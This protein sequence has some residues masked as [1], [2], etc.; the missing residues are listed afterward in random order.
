MSLLPG[1][2]LGPYE[3]LAPLGAGGMGEVYRAKDTRLERTVAIKVLPQHLSSNE[4]VRQRFER[5]AK[6]ISQLSHPHICALHDI[7]REGET[8]Y[9]VM[10]YLEGETLSDRLAKGPLP[11]ERTLRYGIEIADALD[12][13]HRHGIVHRDLKPGNVM[14]TKTGVKLLD[15]GLAKAFAPAARVESLTSAPTVARDVTREGTILGTVSYMA[16]E[17]LEGKEADART[18][19]F[20]FGAVLYEMAT[21]KKAFSGTSQASVVTAIMS[22]EPAPISRVQP[23]C[24]PALDRVVQT[25]LAKDPEE[26]WQSAADLASELSW[27]AEG[28]AAAPEVRAAAGRLARLG[29][30]LAGLLLI[31]LV[32]A[33]A[34]PGLRPRRAA[35]A[36]VRFLVSPP[37]KTSFTHDVTGHNVAMSPDGWHLVFV[38]SEEGR[39]LLWVR[40]LDSV[41]PRRL[42][43]TDG[44]SSPF[45]SPDSRF[46][47]FFAEGKIKRVALSGGPPQTIG[48]SVSGGAASWGPDGTILFA[49]N[50]G[51]EGIYRISSAGGPVTQLTRF[52]KKRG[53]VWHS[54]PCF[55]PDG[56]H[57]LYSVWYGPEGKGSIRLGS[58]D[59]GDVREIVPARSRA[60]YALEGYL[61]YVRE[62]ALLAQPFDARRLRLSGEP[63]SIAERVPYFSITGGADFSVSVAGVLVFEEGE[64]QARLA[65]FDRGG[66]EVGSV[67]APRNLETPAI[68]RDGRRVAVGVTDPKTGS[69]D[70]WIHETG[71]EAP[72]RFTFTP[73]SEWAPLFSPDGGRVAFGRDPG[74]GFVNLRVKALGD[75]GEGEPVA[76]DGVFQIPHDWSAD[77]RF[78]LYTDYDSKTKDDIWILPLEG[79][80]KP[81][82]FL[83]T[84]FE[85][86]DGRFSPGGRWIAYVTDES[87]RPEVYVAA[88]PGAGSKRRVSVEGGWQPRWRRDGKE[89]FYISA[90]ARVMAVPV[91]TGEGFEFGPPVPL[92]RLPSPPSSRLEAPLWDDY[93]VAPDGERFLVR[94]G[95]TSR[96][97]MP[98]TVALDWSAGLEKR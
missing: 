26:R 89:L 90:D 93:D 83:R 45:W 2:K 21:G 92:F 13:A 50:L 23:T 79:D 49:E 96:E 15:F 62:G 40:D 28:R 16:P 44:T 9:L 71:S 52:D 48:E 74:T 75:D 64:P 68:S 27:I 91:R 1:A 88:F 65:W 78:L 10:E 31:A 63:V 85:E 32:A 70:L 42:A 35:A 86:S 7:G 87:G 17:Q 11:L 47:G 24:P 84:P 60:L 73:G 34:L 29:W 39:R 18:D 3:I 53:D 61:L 97:T 12:K 95:V 77:G 98:L 54:W 81:K 36:A 4:E 33:L 30:V 59:G 57:F 38:T 67:G 5:E 82:A 55:L 14:L 72:M 19:I 66:R 8:D 37:A 43:G 76:P 20:A 56:R 51:R 94:V 6:T 22:S 69:N 58:L 46:L 25:C 80:R 41:S